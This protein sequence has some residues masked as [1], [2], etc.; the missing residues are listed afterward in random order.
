MVGVIV[1]MRRKNHHDRHVEIDISSRVRQDFAVGFVGVR[2]VVFNKK[3]AFGSICIVLQ[4]I[5]LF[6]LLGVL[7]FLILIYE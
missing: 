3:A 7:R 6:L 5:C 1:R 2:T 4:N